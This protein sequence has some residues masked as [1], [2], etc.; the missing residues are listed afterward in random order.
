M[1]QIY[2]CIENREEKKY[3]V[4]RV[5]GINQNDRALKSKKVPRVFNKLNLIH[6]RWYLGN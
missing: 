4:F 2:N 6:K 3:K 1:Y 5:L